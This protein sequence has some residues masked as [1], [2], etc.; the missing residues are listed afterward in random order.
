MKRLLPLALLLAGCAAST[1][2]ATPEPE[3][4][5]PAVTA[6]TPPAPATD[7]K[8]NRNRVHQLSELKKIDVSIKGSPFHLWVMDD[9]DKRQ[10]GMMFLEDGDV[11]ADEG[12]VFAFDSVQAAKSPDGEPHGFWMHNTLIPLDIVY[13]SAAG[14]VVT[15]AHGK[16]KDDT[17]L[18]SAGDF[19][20]VIELKA[21]TADRLGLKA[22]DSVSLPKFEATP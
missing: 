11:K 16:V 5:K 3:P 1:P 4:I 7:F 2:E 17:T 8:G 20:N 12:M 18:P 19:L 21:G 22:G 15:V 9:V 13:L 6:T 14:K 10:E